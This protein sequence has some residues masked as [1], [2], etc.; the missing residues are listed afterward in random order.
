[1]YAIIEDSGTQIKVAP[2][3][4]LEV[5]LRPGAAGETVTFDRVLLIGDE[6]AESN[7]TIGTPYADGAAVV[8]EIL[9]QVKG[10]KIDVIK[11][12]RR[13]GFRVK[14]GHRQKY[15]RVKINDIKS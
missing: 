8:G 3:D 13:K 14:Q 15:L 2:G 5:D 11:Y 1:V 7:A 12:K 4:V 6:A 10:E 9:D